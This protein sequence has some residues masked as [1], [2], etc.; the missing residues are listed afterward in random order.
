M[1]SSRLGAQNEMTLE[2]FQDGTSTVNTKSLCFVRLFRKYLRLLQRQ[3]AD[4]EGG[5]WWESGRV[6]RCSTVFHKKHGGKVAC[7]VEILERL[8]WWATHDC[9]QTNSILS[10][11]HLTQK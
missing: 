5:F 1:N 2:V 11:S 6:S 7:S 10:C 8:L 9:T 3:R 4:L